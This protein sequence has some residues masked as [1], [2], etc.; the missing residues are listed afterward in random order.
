MNYVTAENLTKSYGVKVLF[1]NISFNINEGDKIA[2]VAKNGSGKSTLLKILMGKEIADRGNV[3]INKDIQ[4]VLFDQEIDFDSN[5]TIEEFMMTLDSA[6]IRALKNYH[7]SL[8]STDHDFIEK[9]LAEMEVHKA[10]DLE[11]EMKQILSQLK[12]TDLEARMGTLSGGQIKR[13]AL[14]KLLTETRA[15]HRH[16]LLIM[17]EPTNHLDVDM[18]EWLENY[19]SKAK[20]TLLLVTHDRYFLDSVCD[21]IWEMEDQAL[22]LHNGSYATYLENKMIREEN[23]NATIDKANNL[24]RKELEWMRRQ[25]KARTTK[26]KSRIDAFY[27]TEKVAKTDTRK[28]SLELD[29]EMKR[30]GK[31]ILELRD[32]NKSYGDNVLLKDFSYQFQR[33]EKVGIIGKNGAGKSTLLNII[34]ELEPKDSG[35]IETGET[36]KFGYFSQKGLAYKEDERVIDFIKEISENFPLAN[37][38]TISASQFLRLFLFDDQTQYS[39]IS[40]LSGG[41]KR[42]LHLMYVLYQ[43]PNFLIFDEPTNDLDLPT[44]TV[45]ENFL[46][47]FQGSLIIVSHDRYFM[48][49]IVDHVLAFE[50]GG[51]IKDFVGNFSEYREWKKN[52][53]SKI[54]NQEADVKA[55]EKILAAE[56]EKQQVTPKRKL[57]FKEQKELETI[58][59]EMPELEKQRNGI[60]EQLNNETDY[61]KISKLSAELESVSGKLENHELRWLELQEALGN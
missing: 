49:R 8:H 28:Q 3:V 42:R 27:D 19:L 61:E 54:K 52:Q 1:E 20:I 13:V 43:N 32:I 37:G 33:G 12:I 17:D 25:P 60:L 35:E 24:Y 10:W 15:E 36:I 29:F 30:L 16:T 7:A 46:L 31:K 39:P 41:E 55:P 57:S 40:K 53:D 44:L 38:R 48:D 6:P 14:A 5:L 21:I 22:Y 50:G 2:I 18:V 9:A 56:K 58:E 26:S 11:N 47:N 45:L 34:Q 51:K 59:K 23:L 4:V